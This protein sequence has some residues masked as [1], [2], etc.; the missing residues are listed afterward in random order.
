MLFIIKYNFDIPC[1]YKKYLG[2]ECPW[3]GCQRALKLLLDGKIL[4]SFLMFPALIPLIIMFIV[5][6]IH[7]FFKIKN[8]NKILVS[9][10]VLNVV[11]IIVNYLVKLIL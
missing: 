1:F 9:L 3:C 4:D 7:I 8:G 5:L 2:I 6:A 11:I 10:F